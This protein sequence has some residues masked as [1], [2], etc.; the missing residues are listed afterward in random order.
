MSIYQNTPNKAILIKIKPPFYYT[1]DF[2]VLK[3]IWT[4]ININ[5][6]GNQSKLYTLYWYTVN[7]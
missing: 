6:Q 3:R 5:K 4:Q 1:K 2:K 7:N